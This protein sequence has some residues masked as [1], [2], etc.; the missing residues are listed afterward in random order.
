M[1][2]VFLSFAPS[3]RRAFLLFEESAVRVG[4]KFGPWPL[5]D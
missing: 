2:G 4:D 1:H 5:D 3:L